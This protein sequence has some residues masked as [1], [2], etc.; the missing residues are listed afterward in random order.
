MAG[1]QVLALLS[2]MYST[3]ADRPPELTTSWAS[4][5]EQGLEPGQREQTPSPLECGGLSP[6]SELLRS[7]SHTHQSLEARE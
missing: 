5:R 1:R 2:P 7:S 6:S 3:R 4:C